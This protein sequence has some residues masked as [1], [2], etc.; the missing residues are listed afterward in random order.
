MFER[1]ESLLKKFFIT[2]DNIF[3]LTFRRFYGFLHLL[4][5]FTNKTFKKISI[6]KIRRQK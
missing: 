5:V 2:N 6:S 1:K 4:K 3:F